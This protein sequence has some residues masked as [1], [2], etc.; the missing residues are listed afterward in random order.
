MNH[1]MFMGELQAPRCLD[2]VAYRLFDRHWPLS[3][4]KSR[5]IDS[6]DIL[7]DQKMRSVGFVCIIRRDD[8]G[9]FKPC[10]GLDFTVK[11]FYGVGRLHRRRG[12][13]LDCD[14][15]LHS[16]VL[17]FQDHSHAPLTELVEDCVVP[18]NQRGSLTRMNLLGLK[19]GQSMLAN[20]FASQF[21]PIGRL[22]VIRQT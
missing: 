13:H 10:G 21:F 11:P 22:H 5:Q 15:S 3:F 8:I 1:P 18:E 7:H 9:V 20:H 6:F 17:G 12:H 19:P 4:D 2:R 16:P 14:D